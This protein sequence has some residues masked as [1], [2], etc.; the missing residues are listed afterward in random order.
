MLAQGRRGAESF[1][2][3]VAISEDARARLG[4]RQ[5]ALVRALIAGD[6]APQEF[7]AER[8]RAVSLSLL[9]KR[10][11]AVARTWRTLAE[12][13]GDRYWELFKVYADSAPM[14]QHHNALA[15]G[16]DFAVWLSARGLL[17][18][19]ARFELRAV[20]LRYWV[21]RDGLVPRRMQALRVFALRKMWR[22]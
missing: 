6:N 13:L 9:R 19:A 12:S 22:R 17:P 21:S 15:D 20:N 7:D 4:E 14:R 8:V 5:S 10:S 18:R 2:F 3:S 16:R 1:G 11:R